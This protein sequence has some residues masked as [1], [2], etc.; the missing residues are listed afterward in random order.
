[1]DGTCTSDHF[2]PHDST[3]RRYGRGSLVLLYL[4]RAR[5]QISARSDVC[6]DWLRMYD[7][8][9]CRTF[10]AWKPIHPHDSL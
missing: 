7:I 6:A 8:E 5:A 1:M 9:A 4:A 3:G 2:I 10:G